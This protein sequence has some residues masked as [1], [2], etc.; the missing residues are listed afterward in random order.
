MESLDLTGNKMKGESLLKRIYCPSLHNLSISQA[1]LAFILPRINHNLAIRETVRQG[2]WAAVLANDPFGS[3]Q[4]FFKQIVDI[5]Y[6]GIVNWP[7]SILVDGSMRQSMS[8]IPATPEL[9]YEFLKE[10]EGMGL[11]TM[12]FFQSLEQAHSAIKCGLEKLVLHPGIVEIEGLG[13]HDAIHRSLKHLIRTIKDDAPS[14]TVYAYTS[15][16]HEKMLSISQIGADELIWY[17]P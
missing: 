3:P 6:T 16:W 11:Q 4:I 14:I 10:A 17:R 13:N 1:D 12:A 2:D 15:D 9:E 8:T 7:S 5:G